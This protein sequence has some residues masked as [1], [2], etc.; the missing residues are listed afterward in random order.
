MLPVALALPALPLHWL[1]KLT[2]VTCLKDMVFAHVGEFST[3]EYV[4]MDNG[5]GER[6]K[7]K[8]DHNLEVIIM[9]PPLTT[10]QHLLSKQFSFLITCKKLFPKGTAPWDLAQIGCLMIEAHTHTHIYDAGIKLKN[11]RPSNLS[12]S[13]SS[14]FRNSAA[15]TAAFEADVASTC[16]RNTLRVQCRD[17]IQRSTKKWAFHLWISAF[18][19]AISY[20]LH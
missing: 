13:F 4:E 7:T 8:S 9:S 6:K 1:L 19:E 16:W 14:V 15:S 11:G 2:P 17:E 3:S 18:S 5:F 20:D 10:P 12:S